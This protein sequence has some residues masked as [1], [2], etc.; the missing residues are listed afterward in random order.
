MRIALAIEYNGSRFSGWQMQ[1]H[2]T[3]TVQ[4]CVEQALSRVADEEVRV[5]CAGRTDTGVHATGQV[6]SFDC[7]ASRPSRA[8]VLGV[9][10]HLPDDVVSVNSIEV[11]DDFSARFSA[12]ARQYRYVILSRPARA[13]VLSKRVT[14]KHNAFDVQAMHQA[15]QALT[16]EQDFSS[17]RSAACQ[18]EHAMRNVHWVKVSQQGDFIYIDIEANAFLHHMVRN[19]VG[20]LL[21]VGLNEQPIEWISD[22]LQIKDRNQA[23]PTALSDGLYLVKVTYAQNTGVNFPVYLPRF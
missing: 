1:K 19:I 11:A 2:G 4:A 15:A 6:V 17:F 10:A 14:W 9:N 13:A 22:L 12:T 16:G 5:V 20:S 3:R 23:G 7:S 8:W 18:A 21:M